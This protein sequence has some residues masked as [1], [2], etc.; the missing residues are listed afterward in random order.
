MSGLVCT[1]G[2]GE[3]RR[4]ALAQFLIRERVGT[5]FEGNVYGAQRIKKRN[6]VIGV[7]REPHG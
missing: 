7:S 3:R 1:A 2:Y 5:D 4:G 6:V